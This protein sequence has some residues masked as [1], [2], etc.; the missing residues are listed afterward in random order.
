MPFKSKGKTIDIESSVLESKLE[1]LVFAVWERASANGQTSYDDGVFNDD[2]M[3]LDDCAS[4][5]VAEKPLPLR[6]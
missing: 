2:G 5:Q 6:L 3:H 4:A 1:G